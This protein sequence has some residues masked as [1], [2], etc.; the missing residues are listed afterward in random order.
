VVAGVDIQE[1]LDRVGRR[2]DRGQPAG[3]LDRVDHEPDARPVAQRGQPAQ[4][5]RP[6]DRVV[7]QDVV[8]AG[9]GHDLGL[10]QGGAGD[11]DGA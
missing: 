11:P 2:R 1:D 9:A 3:H 6:D 10:A 4:L 7:Q 8:E 5:G